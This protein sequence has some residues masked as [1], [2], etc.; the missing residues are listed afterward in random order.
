MRKFAP[1]PE[2]LAVWRDAVGTGYWRGPSE[3]LLRTV[4]RAGRTRTL[5]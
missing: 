3:S 2:V 4:T 1:S 5:R